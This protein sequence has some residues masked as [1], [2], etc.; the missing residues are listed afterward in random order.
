MKKFI[1]CLILCTSS[2]AQTADELILEKTRL[3]EKILHLQ[4][5]PSNS[6]T[7][8]ELASLRFI[9]VNVALEFGVES[10][11]YKEIVEQH[12]AQMD[13]LI[14]HSLSP[15]TQAETLCE[16]N[17][18]S[19]EQVTAE[20]FAGPTSGVVY[21]NVPIDFKET[22]IASKYEKGAIG[23]H[24]GFRLEGP[25]MGK[26][27]VIKVVMN[28]DPGDVNNVMNN[29]TTKHLDLIQ[30]RHVSAEK[31]NEN[32]KAFDMGSR[33]SSKGFYV[34]KFEQDFQN[35]G[36]NES[37]PIQEI[38]L[39]VSPELYARKDLEFLKKN[40]K[41]GGAFKASAA[42]SP[43]NISNYSTDQKNRPEKG[44]I[45]KFA[46]GMEASFGVAALV[47]MK[48]KAGEDK[49]VLTVSYVQNEA[50]SY[51]GNK[52]NMS[53]NIIGG[54]L[55]YKVNEKVNLSL[56][57]NQT[58][59]GMKPD[60]IKTMSYVVFNNVGVSASVKIGKQKKKLPH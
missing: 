7:E 22:W 21:M 18:E 5:Q 50:H 37:R 19:T 23:N 10:K 9:E 46:I 47:K 20:V 28:K 52:M 27:E 12:K 49:W 32:V 13:A 16:T 11:E 4:K 29:G 41:F 45:K 14:V 33:V 60:A 35:Q 26:L 8:L 15:L 39:V 25:K 59:R 51:V 58:R 44:D 43:L 54:K 3:E 55:E 57:G 48:D 42:F 31:K 36:I 53:E 17:P 24:Q 6:K 1:L 2:F 30:L 56:Y 40:E 34:R 38:Y